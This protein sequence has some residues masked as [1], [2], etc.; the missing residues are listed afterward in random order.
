MCAGVVVSLHRC[1]RTGSA[2]VDRAVEHKPVAEADAFQ[3][4]MARKGEETALLNALIGPQQAEPGTQN[5][6]ED[7]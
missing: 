7:A 5:R 4:K 1:D 2:A 3:N 6:E